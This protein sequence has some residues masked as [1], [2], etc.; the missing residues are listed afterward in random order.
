MITVYGST[1]NTNT[2]TDTS[3]TLLGAKQY[4]TRHGLK[5]VS[6]RKG[7]NITLLEYKQGNKW[8]AYDI[9]DFVVPN[10]NRLSNKSIY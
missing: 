5:N 7:Y 9:C 8:C 2:H 3:N 6:V 1:D 10:P 4:A